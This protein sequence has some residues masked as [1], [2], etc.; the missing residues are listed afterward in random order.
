MKDKPVLIPAAD[1]KVGD[2]PNH[3]HENA[4]RSTRMFKSVPIGDK[5]HYHTGQ[6]KFW[7]E[8]YDLNK[9]WDRRLLLSAKTEPALLSCSYFLF[10]FYCVGG[11]LLSLRGNCTITLVKQGAVVI[12]CL[13]ND[14]RRVGIR[15]RS[16]EVPDTTAKI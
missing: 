1:A 10:S 8:Q 11:E 5:V 7:P 2:N 4:P 13:D 3:R 12:N 9:H 15:Q 16:R 6:G 14:F